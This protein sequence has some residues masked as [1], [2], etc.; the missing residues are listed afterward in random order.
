VF[1]V[2]TSILNLRCYLVV[3]ISEWMSIPKV[4]IYI[5][6]YIRFLCL[7]WLY[8]FFPAESL[9]RVL[10]YICLQS[11][12]LPL[13]VPSFVYVFSLLKTVRNLESSSSKTQE[14]IFKIL[15]LQISE[16]KFIDRFQRTTVLFWDS[17]IITYASIRDVAILCRS[18]L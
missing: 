8:R 6:I 17:T 3:L 15:T 4:F 1:L 12:G 16:G 7:V 2:W 13:S 10:N 18:H 14:L 9:K 11:E 5:S